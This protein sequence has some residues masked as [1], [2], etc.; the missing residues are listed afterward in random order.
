[1]TTRNQTPEQVARDQIDV[2]LS[3][4]GWHVQDKEALDFG[5][6]P[7]IAVREYQTD[8]GPA[9]YALFVDRRAVVSP[10]EI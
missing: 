2:R 8:A 9:D 5:A 7:G 1:M 3:E 6:G 10:F 4:A